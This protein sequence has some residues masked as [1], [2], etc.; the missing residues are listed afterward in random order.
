[1]DRVVFQ[2]F[3]GSDRFLMGYVRA[4]LFVL[5]F[6][7]RNNPTISVASTAGER[8]CTAAEKTTCDNS[9]YT[10]LHSSDAHPIFGATV[11]NFT[12]TWDHVRDPRFIARLKADVHRHRVLLFKKQVLPGELQ[13]RTN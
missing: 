13:V 11:E 8:T 12:I 10:C 5:A 9:T 4:I 3:D 2:H 1:M 6:P 7:G